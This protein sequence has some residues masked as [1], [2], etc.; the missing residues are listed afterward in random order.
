[1]SLGEVSIQKQLNY[2]ITVSQQ[3]NYSDI[4]TGVEDMFPGCLFVKLPK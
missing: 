2:V 1:M 4:E 3:G